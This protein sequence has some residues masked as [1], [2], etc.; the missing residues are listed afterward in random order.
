MIGLTSLE[1][2]NS[3]FVITEKNY[4]FEVHTDTF[5]ELSIEELTDEVEKILSFSNIKHY[6]LQHEKTGPRIV[7][8]SKKERLAK[9]STDGYI[10]LS[11]R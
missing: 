5:D 2:Y 1:V 9:S 8:S 6:H 7:P 11:M 4:N 3:I 10:I